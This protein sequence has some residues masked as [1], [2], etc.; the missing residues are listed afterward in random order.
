[1]WIE[2]G[3]HGKI[4][5]RIK[6]REIIASKRK[7]S[8]QGSRREK[9]NDPKRSSSYKWILKWIWKENDFTRLRVLGKNI[10]VTNR[11]RQKMGFLASYF[12]LIDYSEDRKFEKNFHS[13]ILSILK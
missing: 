5:L 8:S 9:V 11:K 6:E 13:L 1:M 12:L 2:D 10:K 7:F 3:K 4:T